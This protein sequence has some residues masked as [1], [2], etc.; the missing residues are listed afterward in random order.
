LL[1]LWGLDSS[2]SSYNYFLSPAD[3]GLFILYCF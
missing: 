2:F 3:A 1:L